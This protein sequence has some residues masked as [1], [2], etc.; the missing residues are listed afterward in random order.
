MKDDKN[1]RENMLVVED[2]CQRLQ[3]CTQTLDVLPP[4]VLRLRK[5]Q[6]CA[7]ASGRN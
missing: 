6:H 7:V 2:I 1:Q 5:V 3:G 4:Q